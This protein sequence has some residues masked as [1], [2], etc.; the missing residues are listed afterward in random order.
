MES[1]PCH[2]Y[3]V[4]HFKREKNDYNLNW[5]MG[6]KHNKVTCCIS[7]IY[8]NFPARF[9]RCIADFHRSTTGIA[10]A[11]ATKIRL[12]EISLTNLGR[13]SLLATFVLQHLLLSFCNMCPVVDVSDPVCVPHPRVGRLV[14][15]DH[16][17]SF[18][19]SMFLIRVNCVSSRNL[20]SL[21]LPVC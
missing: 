18:I 14:R 12:M 13:L 4:K 19:S 17:S 21:Q 2:L 7:A 5:K 3:L 8:Q 9:F 10:R 16:L 20:Y 6:A 1:L 11:R 15:E